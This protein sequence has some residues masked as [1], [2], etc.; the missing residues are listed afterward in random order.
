MAYFQGSGDC[1]AYYLEG[2]HGS[3]G[4]AP[5]SSSLHRVGRNH[6]CYITNVSNQIWAN[7]YRISDIFSGGGAY[8][9][10]ATTKVAAIKAS[11]IYSV[12]AGT[13]HSVQTS[14]F[15][16]CAYDDTRF[17]VMTGT[18]ISIIT[19]ADGT[20][21]TNSITGLT[22]GYSS[23]Y[24]STSN[25]NNCTV[26][27]AGYIVATI[28]QQT[29]G[30]RTTLARINPITGAVSSMSTTTGTATFGYMRAPIATGGIVTNASLTY[31]LFAADLQSSSTLGSAD[32]VAPGTD[33]WN[34]VRS[35]DSVLVRNLT[36]LTNALDRWLQNIVSGSWSQ[37]WTT[38]PET[39]GDLRCSANNFFSD[40]VMY[41]LAGQNGSFFKLKKF[42]A[43]D[44]TLDATID[45]VDTY[46]GE[47]HDTDIADI[48]DGTF[49]ETSNSFRAIADIFWYNPQFINGA[50]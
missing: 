31:Y 40:T 8:S 47:A 46:G 19:T 32:L 1:I 33:D 43:T 45:I 21:T 6:L 20:K 35:D 36:T 14:Q 50:L 48:T 17:V 25:S 49:G 16:C 34:P 13:G 28:I 26:D 29:P 9:A 41:G 27:S 2:F 12:N 3:T 4:T 38:A 44:G 18:T 37:D 15:A 39:N 10:G 30:T 23:A 11:P 42:D 5:V 24:V 22:G 7:V